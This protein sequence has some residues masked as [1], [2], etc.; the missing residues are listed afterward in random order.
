MQY[1]VDHYIETRRV[2]TTQH[3]RPEQA[4]AAA[5]NTL[6][7]GPLRATIICRRPKGGPSEVLAAASSNEHGVIQTSL[8]W[9]EFHKQNQE[10][11]Q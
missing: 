4:R 6:T 8:T 7:G 1:L 3:D 10:A 11:A 5:E 9:N 2:Q